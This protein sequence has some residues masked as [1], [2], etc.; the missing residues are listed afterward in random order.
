MRERSLQQSA[1]LQDCPQA[2]LGN[3]GTAHQL[4]QHLKLSRLKTQVAH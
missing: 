3:G 2:N 4:R 1:V